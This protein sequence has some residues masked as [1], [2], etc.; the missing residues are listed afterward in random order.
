[1]KA[2]EKAVKGNAGVTFG[3][4]RVSSSEQNLARQLEGLLEY[5]VPEDNVFCDKMSGKDTDRPQLKL[6][7]GRLRDKDT[8][9]VLS[10]DRLGRN[11]KDL[12]NMVENFN[13]WGVRF[14]SLK[15]QVDTSTN[16][17]RFFI[18]VMAGLS[19]LERCNIRER[20]QAGMQIAKREGRL[21]GRPK[22][23]TDGFE[24]VFSKYEK[25]EI[26]VSDAAKLLGVSRATFYRRIK[27][28]EDKRLITEKRGR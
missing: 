22:A 26:N 15:E 13:T 16:L 4:A 7:M 19:E 12:I 27:E 17:G 6:L 9:V 8:V 25:G 2:N 14:V 1:M 10:L 3:Y 28:Y 20:Q 21:T 18:T 23:N 24:R 11:T 5:G